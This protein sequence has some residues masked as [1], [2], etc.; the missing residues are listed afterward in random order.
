M[1]ELEKI[2]KKGTELNRPECV[3]VTAN[4]RVYSADWRGGIAVQEA[5]GSQWYLLAEDNSIEL[6][7]NGICLMPDGSFLIAHLGAEEGGVYR[8]AENGKTSP[9]CLEVNGESLPPTN[10]VHL[11]KR[12]RIWI[13]VSTRQTPRSKGYN[14]NVAD[15]FVVLVDNNQARIVADNLGYTNECIVS[16]D[17]KYLYVNETFARKLT[18]FDIAENGDLSNKTAIAAFGAGTY[19]DGLT[20]DTD[21][22][23]WVTSI[24]SNRV[25]RIDINGNQKVMI[26]DVD[27]DHLQWV[28]EA[29]LAGEMDRPHLDNVKSKQLKSISSLAFGGDD[30]KTAYLGC[31]LDDSVYCFESSFSGHKPTHWNFSGPKRTT[32]ELQK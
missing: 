25:I 15:G 10:Y 22:G 23:I 21:D 20:F 4:N 32:Q 16:P 2:S 9:Y 11:D 13:T 26:E 28:E 1:I 3:L 19:P 18:R 17:E 30:L 6:K 27:L 29:F 7:P 24:V 8:I 12:G 5:D 14:Q 31:L